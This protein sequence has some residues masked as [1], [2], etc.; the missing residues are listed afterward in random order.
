[1]RLVRRFGAEAEHLFGL[2]V[3]PDPQRVRLARRGSEFDRPAPSAGELGFV[4]LAGGAGEVVSGPVCGGARSH[5]ELV[6]T[7]VVDA[8]GRAGAG[9]LR[10][11]GEIPGGDAI[12]D[13]DQAAVLVLDPQ[14]AAVAPDAAAVPGDDVQGTRAGP[15]ERHLFGLLVGAHLAD[16]AV[17]RQGRAVGECCE[18][19][20]PRRHSALTIKPGS[21]VSGKRGNLIFEEKLVVGAERCTFPFSFHHGGCLGDEYFAWPCQ[22]VFRVGQ[23]HALHSQCSG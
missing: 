7:Q 4:H 9:T 16:G 14:P 2:A 18:D 22:C 21:E 20:D 12:G 11:G 1:M 17:Y 8:V 13:E 6:T 23:V 15:C 5:E 19:F 3:H 10:L